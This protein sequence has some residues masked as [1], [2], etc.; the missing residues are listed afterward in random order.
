MAR[1]DEL[2]HHGVC[3]LTGGGEARLLCVDGCE[4]GLLSEDSLKSLSVQGRARILS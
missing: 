2:L 4:D 3:M 1:K